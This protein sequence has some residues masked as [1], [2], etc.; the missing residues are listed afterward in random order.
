MS[1]TF[2][3]ELSGLPADAFQNDLV[4]LRPIRAEADLAY[5]IFDCQ[6]TKEQQEVVNPAGFSIGRAYLNPDDN[7]PCLVCTQEG[8]PIGFIHFLRWLGEGSAVSWSFYIDHREQGC[9][10][11]KAAA[12]LAVRLLKTAFPDEPIKLST[13]TN[14]EKAQAL[15]RALGFRQLDERDGDDLV[16]G[17]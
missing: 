2:S 14:N 17:L 6:L 13:E 16:F 9:G 12:Q 10:Y 1:R 5:A 7:L 15:Y 4:R 11:G 3:E 8:R